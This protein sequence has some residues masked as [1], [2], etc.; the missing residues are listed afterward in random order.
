[1]H[2]SI[3]WLRSHDSVI[4][5]AARCAGLIL[6]NP[7]SVCPALFK[8]VSQLV[9]DVLYVPLAHEV[10]K[11]TEPASAVSQQLNAIYQISSQCTS[12]L[13][14]RPV[15]PLPRGYKTE[16]LP[17]LT[18]TLEA[19]LTTRIQSLEELQ[20]DQNYHQLSKR[21]DGT[22][23]LK[24]IHVDVEE[25]CVQKVPLVPAGK[26]PVKSYNAIAV[27]GTFDH[28]HDGHRLFLAQAVLMARERILVGIA[29]GPLLA[30]KIL[31]ELIEPVEKREEFVRGFLRDMKPWLQIDVV[32]IT[33]VFGP[34][35]T[36][37]SLECLVITQ[38]SVKG[39]DAVNKERIKRVRPSNCT[40]C[41]IAQ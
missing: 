13:D 41:V 28:F 3:R 4:K 24:V 38:D 20:K 25:D 22:K 8:K 6:E 35:A 18:S 10:H 36:D 1:M 21:H 5:M 37:G 11:D 31:T 40:G 15:L 23:M 9:Q 2:V 30:N 17:P 27:G 7:N 12:Q 29:D 32:P 34:T 33:D 26:S 19:V 39:G 16:S 14:I